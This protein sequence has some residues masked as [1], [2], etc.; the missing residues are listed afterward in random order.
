MSID[1]KTFLAENVLVKVDRGSMAQGLEVR[2][3]Y[4]D[5]EMIN[6][7]K[8][9]APSLKVSGSNTKVFLRQFASKQFGNWF[10]KLPKRGFSPPI[11]FWIKHQLKNR[12]KELLLDLNVLDF[13]KKY[14]SNMLEKHS[15]GE[16]NH[17]K[18]IWSLMVL[19]QF[20][21]KYNLDL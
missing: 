7:S 6:F 18:Q 13:N 11:S 12:S 21:N 5:N 1:L 8:M 3:P 9:L 16:R 20:L 15:L 2:V 4:L 14:L 17:G 10:T 19:N